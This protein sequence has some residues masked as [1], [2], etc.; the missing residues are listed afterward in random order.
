VKLTETALSGVYV[1]EIEPARDERGFFARTYCD[2]ELSA[3]LPHI[4]QSSISFNAHRGTVR[5]IH[6]QH[7]PYAEAKLV[8][9]AR[10]A[11]YDVVLDLRTGR[12]LATELTEDNDRMLFV[13]EGF[14]HGFQTLVDA[15]EVSYQM[16][17]EYHP[18]AAAG[19]R[20][21]DPALNIPWPLAVSAIADRDRSWPDFSHD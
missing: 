2:R 21:S 16:S 8:R 1:V 4:V 12:W 9:C 18:A 14:A 17:R 5:G 19:F 15:T 7:A 20:W 11:V 3:L 10:G 13:P 6:Y